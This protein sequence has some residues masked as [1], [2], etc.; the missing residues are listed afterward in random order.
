MK[1]IAV[2]ICIVI[3]LQ[4]TCYANEP[5]N[6]ES[7]ILAL[8]WPHVTDAVNTYYSEYLS[9]YVYL[10]PYGDYGRIISITDNI[11]NEDRDYRY[12]V[13]VEVL[14]YIGAHNPVGKDHV[15]ISIDIAYG[16]KVWKF[17]HIESYEIVHPYQKERII[18]PLP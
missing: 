4:C 2:L 12:T 8:V 7:I 11:N 3:A 18:K 13:V 10:A 9:G 15:I 5:S 1:K 17:Q 14:P 6:E 16:V